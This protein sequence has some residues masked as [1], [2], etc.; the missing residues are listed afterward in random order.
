MARL[1]SSRDRYGAIRDP[2]TGDLIQVGEEY[3]ADVVQRVAGLRGYLS[4]AQEPPDDTGDGHPTNDDGDPLCVGQDDGQC[5][6][7]V[8]EPGGTCWQHE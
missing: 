7:V 1:E 4:V 8:D 6:R 3:P 2:E 5:S